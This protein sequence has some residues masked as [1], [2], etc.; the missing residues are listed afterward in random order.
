LFAAV[1][2]VAI[3]YL[4]G[5]GDR[6]FMRLFS[7]MVYPAVSFAAAV[8]CI[9]AARRLGSTDIFYLPWLCFALGT[10]LWSLG[11]LTWSIYVLLLH[12]DARFPSA[13]DIFYLSGYVP[14]MLGFYWISRKVAFASRRRLAWLRPF[15]ILLVILVGAAATLYLIIPITASGAG[16]PEVFYDL[17]YPVFDVALFVLAAL[18][19]F[20]LIVGEDARMWNAVTL[21]IILNMASDLAFSYLTLLD[22]YFEGHPSD[23]L[24]LS[25]YLLLILACYY[26]SSALSK[27]S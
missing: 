20:F 17:V 27:G 13:A 12:V 3:I 8:S 9:Y 19:P 22:V 11:E 15:P 26:Q 16:A 5:Q 23:L 24:S 1:F 14:W 18:N 6:D 2:V 4:L 7:N 25:G 10:L 21:S